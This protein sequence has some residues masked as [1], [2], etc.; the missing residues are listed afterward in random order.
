[1]QRAPIYKYV[2]TDNILD[3]L[4]IIYVYI[5]LQLWFTQTL[6]WHPFSLRQDSVEI[7]FKEYAMQAELPGTSCNP[8]LFLLS[9]TFGKKNRK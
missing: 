1:M 8:S 6:D 3:Y 9:H 5:D 7:S 2:Y 4:Y